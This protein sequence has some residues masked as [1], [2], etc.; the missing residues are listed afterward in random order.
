MANNEQ[1]QPPKRVC[2]GKIV[3]PHGVKGLVKILPFGDD[4]SL[5]EGNLFTAANGNDTVS[6]TLKNPLG[7]YI[8]AQIDGCEDRNAS[9]AIRGTSLYYDRTAL[10]DLE[11]DE[12]FYYDDLV[13]LKAVDEAG[14]VVGKVIAVENFGAGDL[15]E[16]RPVDGQ[17]YY[18]PINDQYVP[19]INVEEG[20]VTTR[21]FELG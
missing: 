20:T 7:R 11:E 4:A 6:V 18:L 1:N 21:P 8:L 5:L 16:I 12:G 3:A 14:N 15:L 9:E 19:E 17:D 10:P 2:L 13:G